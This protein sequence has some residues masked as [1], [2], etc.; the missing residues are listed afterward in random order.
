M[1]GKI[2][3]EGRIEMRTES[4]AI[5][6]DND[7]LQSQ[8]NEDKQAFYDFVKA[9]FNHPPVRLDYIVVAPTREEQKRYLVSD[10]D[11]FE[12]MKEINPE[13]AKLKDVLDLDIS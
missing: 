6:M 1:I 7:V 9:S 12:R 4:I 10:K 8:F 2:I 13:V 5:K 11:K 3:G